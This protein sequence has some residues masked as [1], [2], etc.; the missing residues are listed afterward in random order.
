MPEP[1]SRSIQRLDWLLIAALIALVLPLR[2]WLLHNT[3]VTARDSIGYIRYALHFEQHEIKNV[4]KW[5]HQHPGYPLCILGMSWPI[6]AIDGAT[7]PENMELSAQLVSLIASTLLLLPMY[8]LGRQFFDRPVSFTASLLFQYLPISAQHLSDGISE[9]LFLL[10]L[11][12]G[13][14][15]CVHAVRDR[16]IGRS[17]LA[18]LF[19]GLA[20]LTRPE[21]LLILP[22]FGLVLIAMQCRREWRCSWPRF[23]ACGVACLISTSLVGAAYVVIVG[24][25]TNKPSAKETMKVAVSPLSP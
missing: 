21:G 23:V 12:S 20:Y 19:T 5:N 1:E 24:H 2:L 18:G 7:T 11:V 22:A 3:E 13:L 15:Q 9:P 14:L 6:R 8:F 16:T 25:I 4:L 10:F 17:V